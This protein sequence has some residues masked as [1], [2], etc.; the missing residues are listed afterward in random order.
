MD[1]GT[2]FFTNIASVSVFTACICVLA[3]RNRRLTGM[4]WFAGA[5]LAGLVKLILQGL[6]GKVPP[7]LSSMLANELYLVAFMMQWM[8]LR[9]FVV[10]KPLQSRWP[11]IA[12]GLVLA[13]YSGLYLGK[14]PYTGNVVNIPFVVVCGASAWMM[15][16]H[17][18]PPFAVVS[19]VAAVVLCGAM[20][21][22][23]YRAALTNL[24]YI[25]PWETIHAQT[26]PRWL[27]SLAGM[28]F[29][30]TCMVMCFLWFLVAELNREL[31]EQA[32]TDSLTG[33]LNRRAMEEA[34]LRE[35][36]RSMRYGYML[37]MIMIDIDNFKHLNDSRGH[38]AGDRALQAFTR[39]IQTMLRRQDLLA[40]TGGD[41]FTILLP[42][43]PVSAG[44]AAAER[45]RKAIEALEVPFESGP[46]RFT[47]SAGVAQL[48]PVQGGWEGMMKRADEAMYEAKRNGRNS[49]GTR[50]EEAVT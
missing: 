19:R 14:I 3:W 38:A 33:A 20:C 13:A 24:R 37:C 26:D 12:V 44:V 8:G 9:W 42:D 7:V 29:F 10:R 43:T 48:D 6:E 27:Y 40:R 2:F 45:V 17:G 4:W 11:W 18:R 15:F 25:R 49:V 39:Q 32:R 41:E 21:V 34:A 50:L 31:A 5:M 35:M 1:Y 16:R 28:A 23:A 22:A 30:A 47:V 46:I 36:A